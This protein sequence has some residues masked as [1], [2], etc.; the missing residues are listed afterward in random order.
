MNTPKL[1]LQLV[2]ATAFTLPLFAQE[3]LPPEIAALRSRY[4]VDLEGAAKPVRDRYVGQLETARRTAALRNDLKTANAI[5]AEIKRVDPQ[6]GAVAGR[7][8]KH[9]LK[10]T[11]WQ[12]N[13]RLILKFEG[14]TATT[15]SWTTDVKYLGGQVTL[16]LRA[17]ALLAGKKATFEFDEQMQTGPGTGFDGVAMTL[18]KVK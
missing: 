10:G 12:W 6:A 14:D 9:Q 4:E 3:K 17:P 7:D 18:T 13:P 1:V 11:R 8:L 16:T 5:D 2:L 15:G